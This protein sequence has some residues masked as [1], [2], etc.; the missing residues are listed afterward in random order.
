MKRSQ[1]KQKKKKSRRRPR[2]NRNTTEDGDTGSQNSSSSSSSYDYRQWTRRRAQMLE[3]ERTRLI[4]QWKAEARAEALASR[5]QREA[6]QWHLRLG[7]YVDSEFGFLIGK[8]YT[9]LCALEAFICNLP[10]TVGAIAMAIATLGVVWYKLAE[11]LLQSCEPVQFHSS[12]CSFPE[13]PGCFFCDVT[14][15]Y[16][17]IAVNFHFACSAIAGVLALSFVLKMLL[18]T[19]VIMDEMSSPTTAS[20][21]GLLCTT[22]VCVFA[23]HGFV[24]QLL[25][26]MA[27][28]IH[29]L[30]VIW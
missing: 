27:A 16:Y 12:Q 30:L 2:R 6:E 22:I 20:P 29:L 11:E 9:V 5:R 15:P 3:T 25:V 17:K 7:R 14:D 4:A 19:Q 13:F 28:C 8:V 1:K 26:S 21:A 10:L 23:G 18:A 24:G